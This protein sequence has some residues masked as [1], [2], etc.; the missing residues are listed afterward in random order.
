MVDR[1]KKVLDGECLLFLLRKLKTRIGQG[2]TGGSGT[3]TFDSI[4]DLYYNGT[5]G[6]KEGTEFKTLGY[7]KS[8]DGG[9]ANY[10]AKYLYSQSAYPWTIDIGE[11]DAPEY[12]LEYNLDGNPKVDETT[13]EY[14][15]K[16]DASGNPIPVYE[17]DGTTVKKKH[18]YACIV[19]NPVNYA[20]FGAK[21]DGTTD[22]YNA[23]YLC[24]KYQ[25]DNYTIEPLSGRRHYFIK[26]ENHHGIIHK[27]NNEPIV[28]SG[29]IDLSGSEL[30]IQDSNA[31]WFGF[32][33]WGDNEEDY[34]SYEPSNDTM[35]TY[36]KDNFIVSNK[37]DSSE[38]K[39]NS[40]IFLKEDPYAVRDDS[41]YLYSEPRYEL[42]LHTMDGILTSPITYDWNNP[43]GLEIQ[44]T[45]SNYETHTQEP[46][47]VESH[48][49]ISYTR[50]PATHYHFIGCDVKIEASA[51]KYCSV[52]WCKCH[53]AHISGFTFQPDSN[54]MHNTVFKNSMIYLWGCYN[55]EISDIV[56][57]NA[58]GKKSGSSNGTSGY[59]IRV[60][61]CL[62]V[63]MHDISVQ[64]YWGATAMNCVKDIHIT[65]VNINRLDIHN[66]FYNLYIDQ[67][68]LFNHAIQIGEGRGVVQITNSNFYVNKLDADSY[69]NA[70]LLEFNLTYG[71]IFEGNILI[72]QQFTTF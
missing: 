24:H 2:G 30:L 32:Y 59:V 54:N 40:L 50:L 67:C 35:A 65:R 64:G 1:D 51:N 44:A 15:T 26:V 16:K 71:R 21:L 57:M 47:V 27:A 11:T 70:H 72:Q 6:L 39:P 42:L 58:S 36:V 9:G 23:I 12:V 19:D 34:Q 4:D 38:I 31:T 60:T 68:N 28:C 56:G 7:Y 10:V 29:D 48:F 62:Q 13:G 45:K 43:G 8:G 17:S 3:L 46:S 63:N 22:D 20:Q 53:N 37:G 33:L 18:L 52:L 55:V 69:P 25:H 5:T 14:V 49:S 66:Y 61:N 41:G